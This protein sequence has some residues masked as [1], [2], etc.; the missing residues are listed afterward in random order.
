MALSGTGLFPDLLVEPDLL[1]FR[2]WTGEA[3][4][5]EVRL[6]STGE[7]PVEITDVALLGSE[8]R[9][10]AAAPM[11]LEPGEE[12]VLP[13]TFTPADLGTVEGDLW[14]AADT[15]A[16]MHRVGLEGTW[17]PD[18]TEWYVWDDGL[19]HETTSDPDHVVDYHGD[20]DLYWYEPSGGHGLLGDA[21]PVSAF[22]VMR[23]YVMSRAG[24]P[25]E[26]TGPFTFHSDS[27]LATFEFA[28]FTYI[29]CDFWLDPDDDPADYIISSGTVDDG[30]EVMVNGEILGF[31]E[32]GESGSF[33][34]SNANP[35]ET[36][37]LIVILVDDSM[38][39]RYAY[40]LAFYED[41]VMVE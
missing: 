26:V 27:T 15:Q 20:H 33:P 16:G 38:Y 32:L 14:I 29:L 3:V 13:I 5:E 30:I 18:A 35:G 8:F 22:G 12:A 4:T 37:T 41:G 23:E 24:D 28:T 40:D 34:L 17:D 21:D 19:E 31:L 7:M 9:V 1:E 25:V 6:A 10:E 2:A 39:D 36:N 11:A